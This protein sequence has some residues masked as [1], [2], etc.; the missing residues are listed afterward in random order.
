MVYG[1][2][3]WRGRVA[4]ACGCVRSKLRFEWK[5]V[6][7]NLLYEDSSAVPGFTSHP[8]YHWNMKNM[9]LFLESFAKNRNM[10][11]LSP[12][13]WYNLTGSSIRE[14]KVTP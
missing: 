12:E 8:L 14:L 2:C 5:N 13:T 6:L 4:W 10:D 9:R 11:P 1:A 3:V 7:A